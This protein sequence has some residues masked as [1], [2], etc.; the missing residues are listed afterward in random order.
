M[1]VAAVLGVMLSAAGGLGTAPLAAA[2]SVATTAAQGA[3]LSSSVIDLSA[4]AP[5]VSS[6]TRSM[7]GINTPSWNAQVGQASGTSLVEALGAGVTRYPGGSLA[8][9]FNWQNSGSWNNGAWTPE[10]TTLPEWAA[11]LVRTGTKGVFT[12]NYGSNDTYSGPNTPQNA[13]AFAAYVRQNNIPLAGVEIGNEI[14]GNWEVNLAASHSATTY[15]ET[16]RA[17]AIAIHAVD[18]QLPVGVDV[19]LPTGPN[20]QGALAWNQTVL[21]IDAPYVQF[22]IVHDYGSSSVNVT[23]SEMLMATADIAPAMTLLREQLVEY[24]GQQANSIQV[25]MTESGSFC[26]APLPYFTLTG[27]EGEYLAESFVEAIASGVSQYDWWTLYSSSDSTSPPAVAPGSVG[28]LGI[29]YLD[30]TGTPSTL[31]PAGNVFEQ[32]AHAI[33]SGATMTTWPQ[34]LSA[35]GLLAAEF[36]SQSS[37]TYVLAN[38]LPQAQTV[39]IGGRDVT[40]PGYGFESFDPPTGQAVNL[41]QPDLSYTFDS[42]VPEA[43]VTSVNATIGTDGTETVTIGGVGF[44]S[45][46]PALSAATD[47]GLDSPNLVLGAL[48]PQGQ[49]NYGAI[50]NWYGL[51]VVD[52]TD[53]QI[54]VTLP[55]T[56]PQIPAGTELLAFVTSLASGAVVG[57]QA[58]PP[59]LSGSGFVTGTVQSATASPGPGAASGTVPSLPAIT[60]VSVSDTAGGTLSFTINGNGF[61]AVAPSLT[62]AHSGGSDSCNLTLTVGSGAAQVNYGGP[63]NWYGLVY[64]SWSDTAIVVQVPSMVPAIAPGSE[65]G[66]AVVPTVDGCNAADALT[67]SVT[68]SP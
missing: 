35:D 53:S 4:L 54:V 12:F 7:L 8:D 59:P 50:G 25:W 42:P 28:T 68:A 26:A 34:A 51:N 47:G 55:P 11:M 31:L 17:M 9:G 33:G 14:Y 60:A 6:V 61:G 65:V 27:L 57:Q 29:A 15:A 20:D 37:T 36:T 21:S 38:N 5:V 49:V 64:Q 43:Q 45:T 41:E 58:P 16:A 67:A 3:S 40:V 24:G 2:G 30:S 32:I 56:V 62:A 46:P 52:W 23:P 18:P 66:V 39:L 10:P 1:A 48:L 22:L 13:Q 19:Q 44:G 63:G